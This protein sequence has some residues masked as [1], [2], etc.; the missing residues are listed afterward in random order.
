MIMQAAKT[1]GMLRRAKVKP[2]RLL[3]MFILQ[4]AGERTAHV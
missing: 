2:E 3:E 1:E 4:L